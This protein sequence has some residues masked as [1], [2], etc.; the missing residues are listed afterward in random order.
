MR[1]IELPELMTAFAARNYTDQ[2]KKGQQRGPQKGARYW[3]S[4]TLEA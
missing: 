3:S 2:G 4:V 1:R